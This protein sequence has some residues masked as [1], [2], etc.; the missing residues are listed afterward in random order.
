MDRSHWT[1]VDILPGV[2]FDHPAVTLDRLRGHIGPRRATLD[3]RSGHIGPDA[4]G[5][6]TQPGGVT[7]TQCG[8]VRPNVSSLVSP[9]WPC[10]VSKYDLVLCLSNVTLLCVWSN[11]TSPPPAYSQMLRCAPAGGLPVPGDCGTG[12]PIT[13]DPWTARPHRHRSTQQTEHLTRR[14][15]RLCLAS[16]LL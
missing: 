15:F 1:T 9:I 3:K 8:F 16:C 11:V 5:G 7:G 10:V 4:S 2:T 13:P 12:L 6:P 14:K